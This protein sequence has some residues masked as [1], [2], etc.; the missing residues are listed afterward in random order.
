MG[1]LEQIIGSLEPQLGPGAGEPLPLDGGITNRN[2]RVR[3]GGSDYVVRLHG[4]DTDLLGI[5]RGAE[6]AAGERAAE[7]GIAPEV[8]AAPAGGLVV[9]WIDCEPL[10]AQELR[11]RAGEVAGHLR[12]FHEC[13][14]ELPVRFD[15]PELLAQ[16]AATI[17]QRG[18]TVGEELRL[19]RAV[20]ARIDEAIGPV[21]ELPCHNDLLPGN[22]IRER[23][24][25]RIMI[26]D[27]EYAG[28]GDPW[29]DLGNLS[30][31]NDLGASGDERMLEGWLGREPEDHDHARL[32]LMRVLSD[33]REAAWGSVQMHLS[34]LDF[35]FEGYASEHYERLLGDAG[36]PDFEG[37]LAAV[38]A[39]QPTR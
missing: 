28:M 21:R 11:E 4:R 27:W 16:F 39:A 24:G 26:V 34:E 29:F 5:D 18:G 17:E 12:A 38:K 33:A 10:E 30:V 3:L 32:R 1:E 15:V 20:A 14:L 25:G 22:L 7:L 31:N 8:V 2:F 37:A 35:D 9:R 36:A 19:T 6:R 23:P 13:G